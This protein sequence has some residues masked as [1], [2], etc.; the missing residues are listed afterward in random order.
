M[1]RAI[2]AHIRREPVRWFTATSQ[3][4][5]VIVSGLL[6]FGAWDP[7]P[8]QLAYVSG[9]V[10]AIAGAFGFTIVRQAVTPNTKLPA[11]VVERA[12]D[13]GEGIVQLI[14]LIVV[15]IAAMYGAAVF[16]GWT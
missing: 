5:P 7:T 11:A 15:V 6:V 4:I 1:I 8:E 16:F 2:V 3:L 14:V 12:R 9:A 13:A 10:A